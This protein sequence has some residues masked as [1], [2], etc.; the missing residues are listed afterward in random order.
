MTVVRGTA[1][2]DVSIRLYIKHTWA[3][4]TN[5]WVGLSGYANV[6]TRTAVTYP[7]HWAGEQ[8]ANL[9]TTPAL[10]PVSRMPEL[11]ACAVRID[12]PSPEG[13]DL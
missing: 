6:A 3:L 4:S 10:D 8:D 9:L 11:K 1:D 12:A 13:S 2:R 7:F 5:A